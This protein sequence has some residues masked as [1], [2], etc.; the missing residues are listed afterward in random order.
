M[1]QAYDSEISSKYKISSYIVQAC[2]AC[3]CVYAG[4]LTCNFFSLML[5]YLLYM[6]AR[7]VP[8]SAH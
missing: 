3:V 8:L 6:Y 1:K 4:W 2:L 5:K 7:V